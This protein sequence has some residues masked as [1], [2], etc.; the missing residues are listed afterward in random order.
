MEEL[1]E[2][3]KD[4]GSSPHVFVL[5]NGKEEDGKAL[6]NVEYINSHT[7]LLDKLSP[8]TLEVKPVV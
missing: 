7:E 1:L 5:K 2:G 4:L 6:K 8:R 3:L